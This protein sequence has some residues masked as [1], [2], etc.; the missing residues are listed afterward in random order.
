MLD[1]KVLIARAIPRAWVQLEDFRRANVQFGLSRSP[2]KG[3]GR[4]KER[5]EASPET[6]QG[7]G[8]S[9]GSDSI[10]DMVLSNGDWS[11]HPEYVACSKIPKLSSTR[12]AGYHI[13]D[14]ESA[15]AKQL[16]TNR[17][18]ESDDLDDLID[19]IA[20]F[21]IYQ[22]VVSPRS[23]EQDQFDQDMVPI[24]LKPGTKDC[25]NRKTGEA[26]KVEKIGEQASAPTTDDTRARVTPVE[27]DVADEPMWS[28][29]YERIGSAVGLASEYNGG[30]RKWYMAFRR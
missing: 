12:V 9:Q 1:R 2:P 6:M 22:Q 3:L 4:S 29:E 25:L 19:A 26:A 24:S 10:L 16:D 13:T 5:K 14:Q 23:A 21:R 30:G 15:D 27:S 7:D 18:D 11:R 8:D 17:D 20:N 28:E